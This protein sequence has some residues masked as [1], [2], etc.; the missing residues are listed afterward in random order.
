MVGKES[1]LPPNSNLIAQNYDEQ[2]IL[3]KFFV[4][5]FHAEIQIIFNLTDVHFMNALDVFQIDQCMS[6]A[7]T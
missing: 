6:P 5:G 7:L 4:D 1:A 2:Q 3:G